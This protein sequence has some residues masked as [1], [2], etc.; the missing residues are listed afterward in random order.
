LSSSGAGG[1]YFYQD[2]EKEAEKKEAEKKEAEKKA[3]EKKA[4]E[5]KAE[6]E[7][8]CVMSEWGNYKNCVDGKR[9]RVRTIQTPGGSCDYPLEETGDCLVENIVP[10][11]KS[12]AEYAEKGYKITSTSPHRYNHWYDWKAFRGIEAAQDQGWHTAKKQEATVA[13][14]KTFTGEWIQ[15]E[16]PKAEVLES[17]EIVPRKNIN[18]RM[19]KN[20][21]VL[22][23]N[24]GTNWTIINEVIDGP[25]KLQKVSSEPMG[26]FKFFRLAVTASGDIN[27]TSWTLKRAVTV[28]GFRNLNGIGFSNLYR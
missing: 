17:F 23:S 14:G 10:A 20:Y 7:K 8:E 24:D 3:A 13:G 11:L 5:K 21:A 12:L 15:I 1:Y 18:Q 2:S 19:P 22:G 27:I 16:L 6:E 25:E 28:E 9:S 26:P 4:A